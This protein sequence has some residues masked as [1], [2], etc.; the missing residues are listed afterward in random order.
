VLLVGCVSCRG[1]LPTAGECETLALRSL[2][3]KSSADLEDPR[4]LRAVQKV[5]T[6]CI[7]T[8]YDREFLRCVEEMREL[9]ACALQFKARTIRRQ[10][11]D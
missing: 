10:A 5:T 4:V 3:V 6:E 2:G 11:G 7:T 1:K 8:P 9:S